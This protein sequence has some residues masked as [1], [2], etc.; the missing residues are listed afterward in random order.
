[1]GLSDIIAE[2]TEQDE[3]YVESL[4][5]YNDNLIDYNNYCLENYL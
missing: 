5:E 3:E 4:F 1:M 2:P